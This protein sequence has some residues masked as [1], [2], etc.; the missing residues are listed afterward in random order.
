MTTLQELKDVVKAGNYVILD[1]ETTGVDNSALICQIA[2]LDCDGLALMNSL[3]NPQV[4]IPAGATNVHHITDQM[5][6]AAPTW[7]EVQPNVIDLLRGNTVIIY[8]RDY[9]VRLMRQSAVASLLDTEWINDLS[10]ACAMLPFA[11]IYGD[12]N[13]Y[14]GNYK[15]QSLSKAA[16]YYKIEVENAHDALGDCLMTLGVVKAMCK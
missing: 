13:S 1:T 15:W 5:V 3:V 11:R 4:P 10:F 2:I 6:A 7:A 8:N 14:R 12:W 16:E 9:D